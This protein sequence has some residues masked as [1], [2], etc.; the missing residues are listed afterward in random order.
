MT[1]ENP[2]I[3]FFH[4]WGR[5]TAKTLA[6]AV[7]SALLVTGLSGVTTTAVK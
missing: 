1:H 5:G 6:N 7:K 4:Y 3:L 2:R